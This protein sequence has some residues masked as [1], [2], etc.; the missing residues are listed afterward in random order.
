MKMFETLSEAMEDLK[1]RGYTYDFLLKYDVLECET[2]DLRLTASEFHVDEVH[3]FE[4]LNDPDDSSILFAVRS[5]NGLKGLIVD[6]YGAYTDSLHADMI[7]RLTLDS[8]TK[9]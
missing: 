8:N 1:K 7:K 3:R 5:N 6:A 2:L 9:H 4:G